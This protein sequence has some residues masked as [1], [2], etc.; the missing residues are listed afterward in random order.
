MTTLL[1]RTYRTLVAGL[2]LLL[3]I[4]VVAI[5]LLKIYRIIHPAMTRL[6][7]ALGVHGGDGVRLIVLG[8]ALLACLIAGLLMRARG[9]DRFREWLERN[10]LFMIPGYEYVRMRMAE[11][12]GQDADA[13]DR[14]ILARIDDGWAPGMLIERAPDGRCT[15]F[16]P[17]A[18]Q[19]SSG[20]VYIVEPSQVKFLKVRYGTLNNSIRNYGKG[21]L[22][23][24]ACSRH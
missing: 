14:A 6:S 15:V 21:L 12:F 11:T 22:D 18:P 10:L 16:M 17:D 9:V 7:D 20:S 1:E 2:F 8:V 23:L 19:C 24:E 3:P 4:A 5:V 13:N